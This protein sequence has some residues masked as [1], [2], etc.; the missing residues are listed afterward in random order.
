MNNMETI[1]ILGI[2]VW[3]IVKILACI[4]LSMYLVFSLVVVRQVKLMTSTLQLGYEGMA[5]FLAYAHL[6]FA[7]IVLIAALVI[8]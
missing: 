2:Q 5:R 4:L 3:L 6:I 7:I 8:L 1:P